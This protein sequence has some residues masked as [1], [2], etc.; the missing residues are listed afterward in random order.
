MFAN[1]LPG[2]RIFSYQVILF[3]S[4]CCNNAHADQNKISK[5]DNIYLN[6]DMSKIEYLI[7]NVEI[8]YNIPKGLLASIAKVESSNNPFAIN[9]NGNS[10]FAK[11]KDD[12]KKY[13]LSYLRK[14]IRNIDIG[15][16]QINLRW[17]S[18]EFEDLDH[19]LSPN[20]NIDYAGQLLSSLSRK[21]GGDWH[22]SV[23]HY[24]SFRPENY[25]KY[26]RK[27]VLTWLESI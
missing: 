3:L 10:Y 6:E 21:Y 5:T 26:S 2:I 9:V 8:K 27:V 12:A 16:M 4:F 20:S 7:R 17:H 22:K 19:M 1:S 18:K 15:V 25:K 23:R 24:H 11:D 13:I 14:G